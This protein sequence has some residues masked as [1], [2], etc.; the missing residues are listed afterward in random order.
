MGIKDIGIFCQLELGI[1]GKF[2]QSK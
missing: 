1:S 2:Q